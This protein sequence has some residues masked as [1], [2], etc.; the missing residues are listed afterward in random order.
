MNKNLPRSAV[1]AFFL[2][3]AFTACGF[4]GEDEEAPTEET[5]GVVTPGS[6]ETP[7]IEPDGEYKKVLPEPEA[8]LDTAGIG[9]T[10]PT[11]TT[12]VDS[13]EPFA[14][15]PSKTTDTYEPEVEGDDL[16]L[17]PRQVG[18]CSFG[19][20]DLVFTACESIVS[21]RLTF[22]GMED[23]TWQA[24]VASCATNGE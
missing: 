7:W 4:G 12:V 23:G 1:L 14:D 19:T 18:V 2:A 16:W 3:L 11:T 13:F 21:G 5:T 10:N 22:P 15:L 9:L 24:L 8:N 17:C 6:F 20:P